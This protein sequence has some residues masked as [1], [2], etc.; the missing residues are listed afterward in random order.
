MSELTKLLEGVYVEYLA[1]SEVANFRR[2][3]FPQPYG[4]S[5]WYDGIGA[6]PFVQVNDVTKN[7]QLVSDTKNK[8]SKLAQPKS[9][10]VPKNTVIVTLQGS[11]GRVAITQ[12]DAYVDRTLAIFE[13][14]KIEIC[15]KYFAYQ[16]SEKFNIEK[17]TARGSTIKT[18]TKEEFSKFKIPIPCPENPEKSLKIQEEI[19][20]ILDRL[21]EE[22]NQLNAALQ[23]EL[24][25]HQKQYDFYREELFK[26]EG[27]E[28]EWKSLGD[29]LKRTKG[30]K[31]TAEQMKK[32][33]KANGQVKIFAGG[34]T[35]AFFNYEDIPIKDI[36]HEPSIIVKSRGF[37]EFEYYDK[38]FSHKS[39]MWSYYSNN[40]YL[41]VKFIYYFLK[42]HE[43]HFQ[44]LGKRMQMPQISIPDT[45][46]FKIPVPC[47]NDQKKS[48]Q[49]QLRIVNLLDDLDTETK[50]ITKAIQKEITL[51]NRQYVYYR[52][53]LLSFQS[54]QTEAE[55]IH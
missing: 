44:I 27:K 16:L 23:K 19:V 29:I 45:D 5:E 28:V 39:E 4:N 18:I 8:I 37:I 54:L 48:L 21:S 3:S 42:I 52:D 38:P 24:V 14:Y 13:D 55:A 15:N 7:M 46:K 1:L 53:R 43:S 34:K 9:V 31:I 2:G 25:L 49:E 26:F 41:N 6:M 33:H 20:R 30:T 35:V 22:T 51:R 50:A 40:N 11:I 12:Y 32:I 47:P 36:N 10:F 17:E